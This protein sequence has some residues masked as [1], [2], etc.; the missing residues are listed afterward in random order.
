[1]D[2]RVPP[3]RRAHALT[4]LRKYAGI[5]PGYEP[6]VK[7]AQ[8]R[9]RE[10]L[11][12]QQL[13]GPVRAEVE[14]DLSDASTYNTGIKQLVEKFGD[15]AWKGALVTLLEQLDG[16]DAFVRSEVLP[17]SRTDFK[18]PPELYAIR[19]SRMGIDVAPADLSK[20]AHAAFDATKL[21]AQAL[22]AEVAKAKGYKASDYVSVIKELK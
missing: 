13:F 22:A 8:E 16:Y 10:R 2:E 17:R 18:L 15:D 19:L 20:R 5:E 21:E 4:R 11:A 1:L 6:I 14:K 3:E 12:E 7:L 9:T